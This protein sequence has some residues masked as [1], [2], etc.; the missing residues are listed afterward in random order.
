[1]LSHFHE[2]FQASSSLLWLRKAQNKPAKEIS[3]SVEVV[4]ELR[5]VRSKLMGICF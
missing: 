5:N 4:K 1:M 3:I 2:I